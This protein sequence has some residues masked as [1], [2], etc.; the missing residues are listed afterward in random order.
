MRILLLAF[1]LLLTPL[2]HAAAQVTVDV[3]LDEL[4]FLRDESLT[5]KVRIANRSGQP[6]KFGQ[7]ADWLVFNL[8]TQD[9]HTVERIGEVPVTGEFTIESSQTATK[10]V[11]LMPW[12]SFP[13]PGRYSVVATVKIPQWSDD[14]V[15]TPKT[16]HI[17]RGSRVWEQ[18]FGVPR[19]EGAPEVRQYSL[20]RSSGMKMSRLYLR[21]SDVE[22]TKVFRVVSL[23]QVVSFGKPEA[24]VD[25]FS[26]LHVL[27]QNGPR[28]FSY[29]VFDPNGDWVIRQ[30]FEYTESRPVLRVNEAGNVLVGGGQRRFAPTDFP[31]SAIVSPG[32]GTNNSATDLNTDT[33]KARLSP[34]A[35]GTDGRITNR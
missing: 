21:V 19:K 11:D 20:V 26:K 32:E 35:P 8:Q 24:R 15:S 22:D 34:T 6:L 17:I 3:T 18:E 12:F 23:G 13:Q 9:G 4:E 28:T 16:F 10:S 31:S 27:L 30:T 14:F 29:A 2:F 1:G 25:R 7:T 33:N 5:V